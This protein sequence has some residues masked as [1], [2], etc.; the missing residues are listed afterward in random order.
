[1]LFAR[2]SF[3]LAR[4]ERNLFFDRH[5]ARI[6][7]CVHARMGRQAF[8]FSRELSRLSARDVGDTVGLFASAIRRDAFRDCRCRGA[9]LEFTWRATNRA[10]TS[11]AGTG[12]R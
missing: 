2:S 9:C 11:D 12:P 4:R 6:A 7:G 10:T 5:A 8:P 3:Q 1:M